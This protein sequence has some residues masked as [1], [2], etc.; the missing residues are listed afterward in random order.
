MTTTDLSMESTVRFLSDFPPFPTLWVPHCIIMS[1][2]LRAMLGDDWRRFRRQHPLSLIFLGALYIF[3]GAIVSDFLLGEPP[4]S[5]LLRTPLVLS[6]AAVWYLT[7]YSPKDFFFRMMAVLPVWTLMG[8][9]QDFLRIQLVRSGVEAIAAKHPGALAYPFV[10]AVCKSSGFLFL[11]WA[12]NVLLHS[13][14]GRPFAIPNHSTK[15]CIL[16]SAA[17]TLRAAGLVAVDE[18]FLVAGFAVAAIALRLLTV[19]TDA[20]PY[21][22]PEGILCGLFFNGFSSVEGAVEEQEK[23]PPKSNK[24]KVM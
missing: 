15:T 13:A 11:K 8:A 6:G 21:S 2:A 20:D 23:Q 5:F 16:A 22:L 7:F 12:E 14:R 4:L 24:Q 17:L 19:V 3:P 1:S 9:A 10:F 18:D